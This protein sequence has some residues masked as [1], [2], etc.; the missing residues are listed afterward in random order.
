M[1]H[2]RCS[3]VQEVQQ[4]YTPFIFDPQLF[5]YDCLGF[6]GFPERKSVRVS[7]LWAPS[8]QSRLTGREK[9]ALLQNWLYFA[10]AHEVFGRIIDDTPTPLTMEH[11]ITW[12]S[13]K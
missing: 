13:E 5:L 6:W 11:L 8:A 3:L 2:I 10:F 9:A 12:D 1:D 7:E 4:V